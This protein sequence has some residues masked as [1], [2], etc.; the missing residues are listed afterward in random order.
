MTFSKYFLAGFLIW[1]WG[2]LHLPIPAPAVRMQE[3]NDQW[4][5]QKLIEPAGVQPQCSQTLVLQ[6]PSRQQRKQQLRLMVI[7]EKQEPAKQPQAAQPARPAQPPHQGPLQ[8]PREENQQQQV[9][10]KHLRSPTMWSCP[11]MGGTP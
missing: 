6:Q 1:L 8:Q 2:E 3:Q 4:Q 5:K 10:I 9:Q 7:S 11:A